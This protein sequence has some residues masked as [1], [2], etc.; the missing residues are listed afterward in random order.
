MAQAGQQTGVGLTLAPHP[1]SGALKVTHMDP[2]GPAARG[3]LIQIGDVL[4]DVDDTSVV[5]LHGG[6]VRT[7][8]LGAPGKAWP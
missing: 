6:Q 2:D 1:P 7:L 5:G 3:G 8:I 4:F